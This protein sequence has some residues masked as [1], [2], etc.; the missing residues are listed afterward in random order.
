[1]ALYDCL[2][3]EELQGEGQ[4]Y[5]GDSKYQDENGLRALDESDHMAVV[6]VHAF[7]QNL[8]FYA[9]ENNE[10]YRKHMLMDTLLIYRLVYL[11]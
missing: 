8:Y 10:I 9:S 7:I 11:I 4:D 1:M 2:M 3:D 6:C 5:A